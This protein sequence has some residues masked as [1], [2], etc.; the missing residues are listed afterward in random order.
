MSSRCGD[1]DPGV[2]LY[3]IDEMKMTTAQVSQMLNHESGLKGIS[4]GYSGIFTIIIFSNI[5]CSDF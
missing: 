5:N 2:V 4:N 1:I 3:L